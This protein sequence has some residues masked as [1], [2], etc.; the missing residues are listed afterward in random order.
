MSDPVTRK[1]LDEGLGE[2]EQRLDVRMGALEKRLDARMEALEQRLDARMEA[3]EQRLDARMDSFEERYATKAQ[4]HETE[5]RLTYQIA[6]S[7][8]AVIEAMADMIKPFDDKASQ[9]LRETR[10]VKLTLDE[11][12]SDPDA[13]SS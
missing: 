7:A 13:H 9:A 1:D 8:N 12:V 4:L 6:H 2:L 10:G 11:H 5:T 3:L